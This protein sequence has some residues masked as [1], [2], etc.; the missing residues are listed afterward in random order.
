MR[1]KDRAISSFDITKLNETPLNKPGKI[2]TYKGKFTILILS[3]TK[4]KLFIIFCGLR[5]N[6]FKELQILWQV[7]LKLSWQYE[8]S[9]EPIV[10]ETTGLGFAVIS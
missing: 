9:S 10:T 8:L 2:S 4:K 6:I 7:T 3:I 1:S 5:N